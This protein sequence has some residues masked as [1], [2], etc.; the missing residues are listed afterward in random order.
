[1]LHPAVW[2][3]MDV[4]TGRG[5]LPAE[6]DALCF[7]HH[8]KACV[9]AAGKIVNVNVSSLE[10]VTTLTHVS[11]MFAVAGLLMIGTCDRSRISIVC[12]WLDL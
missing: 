6:K 4:E 11:L 7:S 9:P 2:G 12:L 5:R 8:F 1:M 3:W 10:K